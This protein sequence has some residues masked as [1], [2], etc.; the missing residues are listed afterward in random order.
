MKLQVAN[1][2]ESH[3]RD[4]N[5]SNLEHGSVFQLWTIFPSGKE[6]M[7]DAFFLSK[8]QIEELISYL[9]RGRDL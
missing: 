4:L 2:P 5:I 3:T 8:E 1:I 6:Q 7:N 9:Q